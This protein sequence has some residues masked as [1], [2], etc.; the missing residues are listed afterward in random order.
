MI[1]QRRD[2]VEDA[3]VQQPTDSL[4]LGQLKA[5]TA[6]LQPK[7]KASPRLALLSC[8][9]WTLIDAGA[10]SRSS[11]SPTGTTTRTRS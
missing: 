8:T 4:N 7:Q 11:S 9:R 2:P 3:A 1:I 6:G 5:A 10:L